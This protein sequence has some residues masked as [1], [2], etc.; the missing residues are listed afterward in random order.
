MQSIPAGRT[1]L[2]SSGTMQT[3]SVRRPLAVEALERVRRVQ[4]APVR[5]RERVIRRA[6]RHSPQARSPRFE[7][8]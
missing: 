7:R 6:W 5:D 2:W 1:T 4:L 3:T 8:P